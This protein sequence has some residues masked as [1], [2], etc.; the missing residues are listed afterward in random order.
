MSKMTVNISFDLDEDSGK[1]ATIELEFPNEPLPYLHRKAIE[2]AADLLESNYTLK[3][4][5]CL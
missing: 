1:V 3:G 4:I 5:T 2:L